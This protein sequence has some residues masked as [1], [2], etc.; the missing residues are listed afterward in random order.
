[1]RIQW[2][3]SRGD[4]IAFVNMIARPP[5]TPCFLISSTFAPKDPQPFVI[6]RQNVKVR[7]LV[8]IF[9]SL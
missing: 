5:L 3:H 2:F 1:V 7:G 6:A 9:I 4:E 8:I